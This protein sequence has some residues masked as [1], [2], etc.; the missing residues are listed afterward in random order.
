MYPNTI[1]V[2]ASA[3]GFIISLCVANYL[4]QRFIERILDRGALGLPSLQRRCLAPCALC[5]R[6]I[7]VSNSLLHIHHIK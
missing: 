4:Y 7:G 5:S 2:I 3:A 6:D 1:A